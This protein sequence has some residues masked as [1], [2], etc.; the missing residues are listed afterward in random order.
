MFAL[1]TRPPVYRFVKSICLTILKL[2]VELEAIG[3]FKNEKRPGKVFQKINP[4]IKIMLGIHK[5]PQQC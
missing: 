1:D 2:I 3:H 5:A 4:L